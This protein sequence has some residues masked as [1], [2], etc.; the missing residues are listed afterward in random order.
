MPRLTPYFL[1]LCAVLLCMACNDKPVVIDDPR[2]HPERYKKVDTVEQI[3]GPEVLKQDIYL[4][5][6]NPE[7]GIAIEQNQVN[8]FYWSKQDSVNDYYDYVV[9]QRYKGKNYKDEGVSFLHLIRN[10]DSLH[11]EILVNNR[12]VLRFKYL[13]DGSINEYFPAKKPGKMPIV[14]PDDALESEVD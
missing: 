1:I 3:K 5:D 8:L 11:Y 13:E 9:N 14:L 4:N 10:G 2:N 6:L 7:A 12:S